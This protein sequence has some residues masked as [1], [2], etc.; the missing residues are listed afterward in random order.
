MSLSTDQLDLHFSPKA[1]EDSVILAHLRI[2]TPD[3]S[4][5][6]KIC[7]SSI[8]SDNNQDGLITVP[9]DVT[10]NTQA[11]Q[12]SSS[13]QG[14]S[15]DLLTNSTF[16]SNPFSSGGW[17]RSA[18][19][20]SW[21]SS[22]RTS[23][24]SPGTPQDPPT[25]SHGITVSW[26]PLSSN[27]LLLTSDSVSSTGYSHYVVSLW[28]TADQ[29]NSGTRFGPGLQQATGTNIQVIVVG[30]NS[31]GNIT[32]TLLDQNLPQLLYSSSSYKKYISP[33]LTVSSSATTKLYVQ[34]SAKSGQGIT[35]DD[36][37][38]YGVT[39]SQQSLVSR[40]TAGSNL[41]SNPNLNGT[42]PDDP[43]PNQ[44]SIPL[45]AAWR[46]DWPDGNVLTNG[47]FEKHSSNLSVI[48]DWVNHNSPG[49]YLNTRQSDAH[50]GSSSIAFGFASSISSTGFVGS[51]GTISAGFWAITPV[52]TNP[53]PIRLKLETLNS[54]G[55]VLDSIYYGEIV[56][57][58]TWTCYKQTWTPSVPGDIVRVT[59]VS[60]NTSSETTLYVAWVDDVAI[61]P[62]IQA[63]ETRFS[64]WT[65]TPN[66]ACPEIY[67]NTY[68]NNQDSSHIFSPVFRKIGG[69]QSDSITFKSG[70]VS[71]I[72]GVDPNLGGTGYQLGF[73]FYTVYPL[74]DSNSWITGPVTQSGVGLS[75]NP[76]LRIRLIGSAET[77]ID[78]T[79]GPSYTPP[80]WITGGTKDDPRYPSLYHYKALLQQ[81]GLAWFQS[82]TTAKVQFDFNYSYGIGIT[83]ISL[84]PITSGSGGSTSSG[85]ANRRLQN[86][87]A[88][89][90]IEEDLT[91][92]WH[93][94]VRDGV[95]ERPYTIPSNEPSNSWLLG[96]GFNIGD[97]INLI[98][99]VPEYNFQPAQDINNHLIL[100]N[101]ELATILDSNRILLG[102]KNP[103]YLNQIYIN[104]TPYLTGVV[105]VGSTSS[106]DPLIPGSDQD[107][108]IVSLSRSISLGDSIQVDYVYRED[109]YIYRGF[110]DS[111][112]FWDLDLNPAYGHRIHVGRDGVGQPSSTILNSGVM[113]WALPTAAYLSGP[114]ATGTYN[115]VSF[116][117]L[118][119]NIRPKYFIRHQIGTDD[120][121]ILDIQP[122]ALVL[123]KIFILP[124]G[125]AKDIRIL[126]CRTRGGGFPEDVDPDSQ[127]PFF[128][129]TVRSRVRMDTNIWQPT[130]AEVAS[131]DKITFSLHGRPLNGLGHTI[132]PSGNIFF[133][134][135][136]GPPSFGG[137]TALTNNYIFT[138][139]SSGHIGL[140]Y[141]DPDS[142]Y[143]G[144]SDYIYIEM[145]IQRPYFEGVNW[146]IGYGW[147]G[148]PALLNGVAVIEV[149]NNVLTGGD[150]RRVIA[151]E[152]VEAA[153]RRHI[154]A[155]IM[156]I[157]KYT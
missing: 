45:P 115:Y 101:S 127:I 35:V 83:N 77:P 58:Y 95:V 55:T 120:N 131:G 99:T 119:S 36:I 65:A 122:S 39:L 87:L 34:Y 11:S 117:N 145:R 132:N 15:V 78:T 112:V 133:K 2:P 44:G 70:S 88:V 61:A 149:S 123:A 138:A 97:N 22:G 113:I 60:Q 156:P 62:T 63:P 102:H 5:D 37:N 154:A 8:S 3:S 74:T 25:G 157:I 141:Q 76:S 52:N 85:Q 140:R 103:I 33:V 10:V 29:N 125:D 23:L 67:I 75:V 48:P 59:L 143:S 147:D 98:Y 129:E 92:A 110:W 38:L 137:G 64:N 144:N 89:D 152:D 79:I 126:D 142:N 94:L 17:S 19:L 66:S 111:S 155:G 148:Q 6:L 53:N 7:G 134:V 130:F 49:V 139:T 68:P 42:G 107:N 16:E 12:S 1:N 57:S 153:V 30:T 100:I 28:I 116:L 82:S 109:R 56:P 18:Y 24:N 71:V 91:G 73:D 51:A 69:T 84:T 54:A 9:Q 41:L 136:Q 108:G 21:T 26:D 96:A 80:G 31:S 20:L 72:H 146:D 106:N 81:T 14:Y 93:I 150:G 118:P 114:A 50:S 4:R 43:A 124:P 40:F 86:A 47:D 13:V 32:E 135:Y 128:N 104:N 105:T 90:G 27:T 121:D 46:P 151:P